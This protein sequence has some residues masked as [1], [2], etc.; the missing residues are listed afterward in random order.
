LQLDVEQFGR[1]PRFVKY[2]FNKPTEFPEELKGYFDAVVIDPPFITRD[3]WEQYRISSLALLRNS[4][5]A[6]EGGPA[7]VVLPT[8][9]AAKTEPDAETTA[10]PAEAAAAPTAASDDSASGSGN[11]RGL[12]L[13]TTIAENKEMMA[14]M[15]GVGP[16]PFRPCI[17]H[18]V[19]QYELY[20]NFEAAALASANPEVPDPDED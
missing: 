2:D 7:K 1:D 3:V 19:Y 16:N 12:V 14:E 4:P 10:A 9:A 5:L 20:T 15:L 17:P 8:A 18:L 11:G 6:P 13:L